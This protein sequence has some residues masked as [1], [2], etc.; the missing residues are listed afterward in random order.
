MAKQTEPTERSSTTTTQPTLKNRGTKT[1][2]DEQD[3]I[4]SSEFAMG[5]NS[6]PVEGEALD[7][8][9]KSDRKMFDDLP[10]SAK[11][12]DSEESGPAL[13]FDKETDTH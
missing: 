6:E 3:V 11:A 9:I 7:A 8:K 13:D 4:D 10:E 5:F 1:K 12:V 2:V